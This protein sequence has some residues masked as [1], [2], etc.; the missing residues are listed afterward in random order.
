[1]SVLYHSFIIKTS[2][3]VQERKKLLLFLPIFYHGGDV[4]D[5]R[6]SIPHIIPSPPP[7]CTVLLIVI[8]CTGCLVHIYICIYNMS[9]L[10][11]DSCDIIRQT[12]IRESLKELRYFHGH[13]FHPPPLP[14][15]T[16]IV[17]SGIGRVAYTAITN[18]L[19]SFYT[20]DPV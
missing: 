6:E 1:M 20:S 4:D 13:V 15:L 17:R 16:D 3:F 5:V 10:A 14:P 19:N 7:R 11:Y 2:H 12:S 8:S 9:I 18:Y